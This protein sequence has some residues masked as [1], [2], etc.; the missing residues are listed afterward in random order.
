[1]EN[2]RRTPSISYS[3]CTPGTGCIRILAKTELNCAI[4]VVAMLRKQKL[5]P[6]DTYVCGIIKRTE[7]AVTEHVCEW[8][9]NGLTHL[10][11]LCNTRP[12]Q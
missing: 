6:F 2:K 7:C 11:C 5:V 10:L 4:I 9:D 1:M 3:L 12:T 8:Y